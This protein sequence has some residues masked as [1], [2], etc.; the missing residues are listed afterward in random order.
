MRD[1]EYWT[2]FEWE[3]YIEICEKYVGEDIDDLNRQ[4]CAN[5]DSG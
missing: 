2:K 1:V 3:R 5:E 4:L